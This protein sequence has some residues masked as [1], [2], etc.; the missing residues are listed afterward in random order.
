MIAN[1]L[2]WLALAAQTVSACGSGLALCIN[3]QGDVRLEVA[4]TP[5]DACAHE[6]CAHAEDEE[7]DCCTDEEAYPLAAPT[8]ALKSTCDCLHLELAD[9][10]LAVVVGQTCSLSGET[11]ADIVM[12]LAALTAPNLAI[13]ACLHDPPGPHPFTSQLAMLRSVMLRC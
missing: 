11:P 5:C 12:P 2:T 1:L 13:A 4:G 9:P 8:A 10:A 3:R 6:A 7:H